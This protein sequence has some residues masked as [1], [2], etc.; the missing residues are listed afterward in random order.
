MRHT[1]PIHSHPSVIKRAA[2]CGGETRKMGAERDETESQ[3]SE[4][5]VSLVVDRR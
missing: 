4:A 1:H 5:V 2:V 3:W